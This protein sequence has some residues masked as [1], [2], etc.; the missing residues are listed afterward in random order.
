VDFVFAGSSRVAAAINSDSF[1]QEISRET[2][3]Q[4]RAINIGRGYTTLAEHYLLLRR[5]Y[6]ECGAN[7]ERATVLIEGAEGLPDFST[8]RDP[9]VHPDEPTLI[10]PVIDGSHVLRM[11]ME[12]STPL[13]DKIEVSVR[14][15]QVVNYIDAKR[16]RLLTVG[17]GLLRRINDHLTA[18]RKPSV[19]G[20]IDL[21]SR[22]GVLTDPAGVARARRL[23]VELSTTVKAR[24]VAV[25]DW[26]AT[27]LMDINTLV[28]GHDGRMFVFRM[29]VSSI[30]RDPL[31]T[32]TRRADAES[33]RREAIAAGVEYLPI[34]FSTNDEDFPD[35][36]HLRNSR[37]DEFSRQVAAEYH[38]T[39]LDGAT[40]RTVSGSQI[41]SSTAVEH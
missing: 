7:L 39:M 4:V 24:Q 19:D 3:T 2:G 37:A 21:S 29:P 22:G 40:A 23:A 35:Y 10:V 11:W 9:W 30:Q 12:S 31:S 15:L 14:L 20:S 6:Q 8:F 18:H 27:V 38:G 36:W 28:R 25:E 33:F 34:T 1:V 17:E 26:S 16:R 13:H 32:P 5:L 41:Q